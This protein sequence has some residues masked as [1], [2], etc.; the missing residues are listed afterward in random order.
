MRWC[1]VVLCGEFLMLMRFDRVAAYVWPV[2][3]ALVVGGSLYIIAA[4]GWLTAE[5]AMP[6]LGLSLVLVLGLTQLLMPSR[7]H[8]AQ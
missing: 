8:R 7:R 1:L 6:A 5:Y 4:R 2:L 3:V